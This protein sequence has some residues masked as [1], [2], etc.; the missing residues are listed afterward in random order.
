[1]SLQTPKSERVNPPAAKI[2][3]LE[4][5]VIRLGGQWFGVRSDTN[6][7]LLSF[8]AAR[9]MPPA[10]PALGQLPGLLGVWGKEQ[11]PVFDLAHLL[12]LAPPP[13]A[14]PPGQLI[15]VTLNRRALGFVIDQA[16]E[17]QRVT[18][19]ELKQL[20]PFI[21]Q[22]RSRPVVWAVWQRSPTELIPLL[23][24]QAVLEKPAKQAL[25]LGQG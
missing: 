19:A 5:L 13:Q 8:E 4:L 23:D 3:A 1:M 24:L 18:L 15:Q 7:R 9:L 11:M 22:L 20:P 12:G 16:Q 14:V 21:Q 10:D 25:L 17:I 2:T 6:L